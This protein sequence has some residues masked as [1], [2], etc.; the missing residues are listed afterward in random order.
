MNY[1]EI[2]Q[3]LRGWGFGKDDIQLIRPYIKLAYESGRADALQ[4]ELAKIDPET[5][6]MD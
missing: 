1:E 3:E 4:E 6:T 2:E 5:H